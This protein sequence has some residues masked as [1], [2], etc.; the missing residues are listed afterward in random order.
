[1]RPETSYWMFGKHMDEETASR[2]SKRNEEFVRAWQGKNCPVFH[3]A[4]NSEQVGLLDRLWLFRVQ[5]TNLV[6][7]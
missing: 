7:I 3:H 5:N 1:M 6:R 4:S 2:V